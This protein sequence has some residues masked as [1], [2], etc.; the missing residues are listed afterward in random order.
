MS[1]I[2]IHGLRGNHAKDMRKIIFKAFAGASYLGDVVITI[3]GTE[4][5]DCRGK[6]RPYLRIA[7]NFADADEL[8]QREDLKNRLAVTKLDLEFLHLNGFVPAS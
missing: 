4:V 8:E 6:S 1:N 7:T 2:E 5:L 3:M